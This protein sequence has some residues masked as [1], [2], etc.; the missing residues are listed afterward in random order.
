MSGN[1]TGK[2]ITNIAANFSNQMLSLFLAFFSRTIFIHVLGIEYLGVNSVFNDILGLLSMADLGF[3]TAMVYSLYK[4]LAEQDYRKIAALVQFYRKIY[5]II[6]CAIVV[7]GIALIPAL[8][9]LV[10][11]DRDIPQLSLYYVLA[12][13]GV[14]SSYACYYKT[15][16][17]TAD[18]KGYIITRINMIL[19]IC[20]TCLQAALLIVYRNYEAYLV[21]AT[22]FNVLGNVLASRKASREYR[23]IEQRECLDK[24]EQ[25]D[26]LVNVSSAF[27]YKLSSILLNATDN[28]LISVLAG[29]VMVGYYSN[30]LMI[31]NRLSS[32]YVILFTSLTASIGNLV[33]H[34]SA[35]KQYEVFRCEQIVSFCLSC[36]VIPCF[37]NTVNDFVG[38]WLGDSYILDRNVVLAVSLNLYLTCVC[39]PLWSYREAVGLYQKTK[40]IML[41]CAVLNII[42]SVILGVVWGIFGILLSS[43]LARLLTYIWLEPKLL[44]RDYFNT[45]VGVYYE[46]MMQ[47]AVLVFAIILLT[48]STLGGISVRN[49]LQWGI[50]AAIVFAFGGL[51]AYFMYRKDD[52]FQ[53]LCKKILDKMERIIG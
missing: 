52:G 41:C 21:T 7:I 18:Q 40:W 5:I 49:Y 42:L 27:L 48:G 38:I 33:I 22:V 10:R 8:P 31:T 28:I 50:K 29:T 16:V 51:C 39:Q 25:R 4:P 20:R 37:M 2:A 45:R 43:S 46:K 44:F 12:L 19:G 13:I 3:N 36:A 11:L 23:Y 30:Y 47:N 6:V 15:S 35:K 24:K 14:V 26:L 53:V 32:F 17:L 1:R 34:A 9:Y